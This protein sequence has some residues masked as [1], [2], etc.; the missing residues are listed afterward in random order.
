MSNKIEQIKQALK[1]GAKATKYRV[2]IVFP[3][4]V[5]HKMEFQSLNCLAKATSFPQATIGQIEVYNQGRKIPIPGDTTYDTTWAVTFYMDNAHQVRKDFLNW[6]KACDNFHANT[7]SGDPAGL[8]TEISVSQ[9]D[10]LEKEVAEYTLRNCWPHM[11]GEV[12][13]GADQVDTLQEFD[14][15]FSF[16]DFYINGGSEFNMPM[17]GRTASTNVIS[18]DQ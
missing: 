5:E 11:V 10:S 3:Q 14:V 15:T 17:D 12:S 7:H 6:Q 1:G 8:M 4:N 13:V 9:L 18:V 2:K 16:S